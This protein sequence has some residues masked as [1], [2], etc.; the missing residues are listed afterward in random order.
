[1]ESSVFHLFHVLNSFTLGPV[2]VI[3]R[4]PRQ[5]IKRI[6][7]HSVT[8]IPL[9]VTR[10]RETSASSMGATVGKEFLLIH[11]QQAHYTVIQDKD[12]IL[13]NIHILIP[14]NKD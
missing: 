3:S 14:V 13:E 4:L 11:W 9:H 5:D 12:Y 2:S 7:I 1:M 8:F 6:Q 10:M